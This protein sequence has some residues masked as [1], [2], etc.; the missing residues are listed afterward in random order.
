MARGQRIDRPA[1]FVE[2]MMAG[3]G[4]GASAGAGKGVAGDK[5]DAVKS[6]RPS[7]PAYEGTEPQ[8]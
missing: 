7:K 8:R 4:S 3:A 5:D 6:A 2:V 1:S